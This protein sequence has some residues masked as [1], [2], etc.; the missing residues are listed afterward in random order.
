MADK[1]FLLPDAGASVA[2]R[3]DDESACWRGP[4]TRAQYVASLIEA[5]PDDWSDMS[6]LLDSTDP[7][8][9]E[10]TGY[11]FHRHGSGVRIVARRRWTAHDKF[12]EAVRPDPVALLIERRPPGF[13]SFDDTGFD[14]NREFLAGLAL[15][16]RG[17]SVRGTRAGYPSTTVAVASM[18]TRSQ[19]RS[20]ST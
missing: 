13:I 20:R 1:I 7:T 3:S 16:L 5:V 18:P 10:D 11:E 19:P 17:S 8:A 12:A 2:V 4:L 15:S 14:S 6:G 9:A